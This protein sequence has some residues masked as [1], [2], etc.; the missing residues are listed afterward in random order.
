M[1]FQRSNQLAIL[2]KAFPVVTK[3]SCEIDG[4]LEG[5]LGLGV[6]NWREVAKTN[7]E[8]TGTLGK[9]LIQA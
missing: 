4:L 8:G 5:R 6:K 1:S 9:R 7:P 2:H 3:D